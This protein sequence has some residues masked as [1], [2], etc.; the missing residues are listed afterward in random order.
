M[1]ENIMP[2]GICFPYLAPASFKLL[3]K[4]VGDRWLMFWK[5]QSSAVM[6]FRG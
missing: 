4:D 1:K 5:R 2:F 6:L 3:R